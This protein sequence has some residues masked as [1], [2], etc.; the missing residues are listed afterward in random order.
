MNSR[1]APFDA[2]A[3]RALPIGMSGRL[4]DADAV[5]VRALL[6]TLWKA[7]L[8]IAIAA[9][10]VGVLVFALVSL[11][12][13]TYTAYA[14]VMLDPRKVQIVTGSQLLSDLDASESVVNGELAVLRSNIL[15]GAV[16]DSMAPDMLDRIDP[17]LKPKSLTSRIKSSITSVLSNKTSPVL[18]PEAAA[19][20]RKERLVGTV[21][22][23]LTVYNEPSSYVMAIKVQ[24]EDPLAAKEVANAVALTYIDSQLGARQ[25][26]V[27]RATGWLEERLDVLRGE[28]EAAE[29]AVSRFQAEALI[30]DGGTLDNASQQL[31]NLTSQLIQARAERVEAEARLEQLNQVIDAQGMEAA[32]LIVD[33]LALQGLRAQ[34]LTL[35]Q[36]D[37]VWARTYD[38]DQDRRVK[39][40]QELADIAGAMQVEVNSVLAQRRSELEIA[41][42]REESLTQSISELQERI[43]QISQNRL[44]LRQLEREA[45]AA[46]STYEGLLTRA[47]EARTQRQ[48]Q[49][50]DAKMVEQAVLPR[51]PSAPKS[52]MLAVLGVFAGATFMVI[53]VFFN[54][55]TVQT[56][57]TGRELESET[58]RSVLAA[59]PLAQWTDAKAA[60]ADLRANP[61]SRFA[62]RIRQLRT[63]ILMRS[64]EERA[65]SVMLMSSA[66]GEGKTTTSLALAQMAAMAGRTT[67]IIDCDLRRPRLQQ[68]LGLPMTQDFTDFIAGTAELPDIIYHSEEAGFDV[69]AAKVARPEAADEL[70]TVWLRPLIAELTRVYD[71]VIVDAPAMLAVSDT[72]IIAET[73]DNRVFLVSADDTPRAA[74]QDALG[75][76][77]DAGLPVSGLILNKIDT[78][79]SPDPYSEGYSYDS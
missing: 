47:T 77:A 45:S 55:M 74:V 64:G 63:S 14:K 69:I 51:K 31:A 18:T 7:R 65:Q 23:K 52:K 17:A 29:A 48:L 10:A 1:T 56:F 62:E 13:P 26:A 57:R 79:K 30:M 44:G 12:T 46:R 39:I 8:K 66:P 9:I 27:E 75:Q 11:I 2:L 59:V 67:I 5:D 42:I 33:T 28:V 3:H 36:Q 21:R 40:R 35:R 41:R 68:A 15:L 61:Y 6:R 50:A 38:K 25:S 78:K 53:W 32:A 16:V 76:L 73:V 58:G 24:S 71:F 22:S 34:A 20:R 4:P 70:D 49:Q 37:A 54:E 72:M 60:L 19:A 43:V